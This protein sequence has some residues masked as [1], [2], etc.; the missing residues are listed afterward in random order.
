MEVARKVIV[1][2]CA[3]V[4]GLALPARADWIYDVA[5]L[6]CAPDRNEALVR[7]GTV[8][9]NDA[10]QWH[11]LPESLS[12]HWA[13]DPEA[14]NKTCQLANGQ[15]VEIQGTAGQTFAYGMNGGMLAYWV[16][17]WIDRKT[18]LS[19]QLVR[20]GY[21]DQSGNDVSVILVTSDRLRICD[22]P[23]S[24]P[25]SKSKLE[26]YAKLDRDAEGCF[27]KELDLESHPLDPVQMAED[28][29]LGTY[30]VAAT[31]S[32]AF[33]RKFIAP[34][35]RRPGEER[36]NFRPPLVET[37]DINRMHFKSERYRRAA[38]GMR[39]QWDEF[40]FDNDGQ[41]D[42]VILAGAD[43]HYIDGEI[44]LFR[45]GHHPEAL[46]SLAAVEDFDDYPDWARTNGFRLIT[47]AE[48][49]YRTDR[50]TRFSLF[51]IDGATFM[52]AS[53]TNRSL[54][55]SAVLY[56]Y[57][58]DGPYGRGRFDTI[59]MFQKILPND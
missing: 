2:C 59:C 49:P 36:L 30:T 13:A 23:N 40:D 14:D 39:M 46:E 34:D 48:T 41:R 11:D 6:Q 37:L 19:R 29:Q 57:R 18:V 55:P 35:D 5:T 8:H 38:T 25:P 47:G 3:V 42:T 45:S 20:A 1:I 52:L 10:P 28:I 17:L 7:M 12:P 21:V 43:N 56:R 31:Y 26:T 9:N 54:R 50:Y 16:S 53:P 58:T 33:C 24:L 32:E 22:Q 51:W 15:Q 27:T 4:A 44:I